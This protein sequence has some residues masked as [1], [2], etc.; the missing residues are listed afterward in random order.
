FRRTRAGVRQAGKSDVVQVDCTE[1]RRA[2]PSD[3]G[4]GL[5]D[6]E[7]CSQSRSKIAFGN[8]ESFICGLNV[9]CLR[10]EHAISL[11]EIKKSAA[12]FRG[13]G[14]SSG[15]QSLHGR[16]APGARGLDAPFGRE[17]VENVPCRVYP[18][19]ISIIKFRTD[20]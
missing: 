17:P 8:V 20:G 4:C 2:S 12:H 16:F 9:T 3:V 15:C 18:H 6:V 11:L 19:H 7:L 5:Q 1:S 13:N 14:A 10:F